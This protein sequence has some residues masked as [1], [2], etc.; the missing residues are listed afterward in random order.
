MSQDLSPQ[1]E[2]GDRARRPRC[3]SP[4][5]SPQQHVPPPPFTPQDRMNRES[6]EEAGQGEGKQ[7]E[8]TGQGRPHSPKM[9][10]SAEG[11][12]VR[13]ERE[14]IIVVV[15]SPGQE[16]YPADVHTSAHKSVLESANPAW[17]RSVHL[18]APG[19][20]SGQQPVSGTA[21]PGVVIQDKSF[22][23]SVDTTKRVQTLR[24]SECARARGQQAPP[25]ANKPTPWPRAN[26]PP[27]PPPRALCPAGFAADHGRL[28]ANCHLGTAN[29][30]RWAARLELANTG[31]F[32]L[33]GSEG[34]PWALGLRE[35]IEWS[36]ER[37]V[38]LRCWQR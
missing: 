23:V 14:R 13:D 4:S 30:R 6:P 8:V 16:N 2:G 10:Q 12:N 7:G 26:T 37:G 24:G 22:R 3:P 35:G 9:V 28:L 38:G 21:D 17:T 31:G 5:P 27:P 20:Q 36:K 25:K 15:R 19:Q 33:F 18:D 1:G 29:R 32:L 34:P 11:G